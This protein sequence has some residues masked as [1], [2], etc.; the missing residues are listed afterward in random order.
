MGVTAVSTPPEQQQ[1]SS[2]SASPASYDRESSNRCNTGIPIKG[3]KE[4]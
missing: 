3:Y 4:T 2:E 1:H